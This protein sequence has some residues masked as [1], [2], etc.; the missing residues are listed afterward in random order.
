MRRALLAV[1]L[2]VLI[3]ISIVG[4]AVASESY[5]ISD[6]SGASQRDKATIVDENYGWKSAPKNPE[7]VYIAV[8]APEPYGRYIENALVAVVEKH[9]LKPM[10]VQNITA[11]DLK[12]RVVIFYAPVTGVKNSLL[13]DERSISGILYYSYA[14]DA[15]SVVDAINRGLVFSEEKIGDSAQSLCRASTSRLVNMKIA[16]IT[17]DV[18]YWW[19]L[20]ARVGK[21]KEGN[22][23][24]MIANEIASQLDQFLKSDG[25]DEP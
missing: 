6:L 19:N 18:A 15:K 24:E 1:G 2:A 14:G 13:Y 16:N 5:V 4:I 22:P 17:C 23:Y 3:I 10:I 25:S 7:V 9:G 20:K 11:H 8:W 12:G 21:L